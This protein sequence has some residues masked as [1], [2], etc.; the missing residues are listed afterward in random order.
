MQYH[1]HKAMN[2]STVCNQYQGPGNSPVFYKEGTGMNKIDYIHA[3]EH[4]TATQRNEEDHH[5]LF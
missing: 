3:V 1:Q 4:N 2:Y 5:P